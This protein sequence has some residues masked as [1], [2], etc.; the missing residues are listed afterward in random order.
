MGWGWSFLLLATYLINVTET[1]SFVWKPKSHSFQMYCRTT[2]LGFLMPT[3]SQIWRIELSVWLVFIN[4]RTRSQYVNSL[5]IKGQSTVN[6]LWLLLLSIAWHMFT[7][8]RCYKSA[9]IELDFIAAINLIDNR[10]RNATKYSKVCAQLVL[11]DCLHLCNL[12]VQ[13]KETD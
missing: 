2:K 8:R 3:L 9:T 7:H 12:G 13:Q 5:N 11:I 6:L 1:V 10:E 4:Q